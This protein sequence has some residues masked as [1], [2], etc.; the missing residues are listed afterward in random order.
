MADMADGYD[1]ICFQELWEHAL[2]GRIKEFRDKLRRKGF[3]VVDTAP[4][5]WLSSG[6]MVASRYPV[7]DARAHIF[8]A[9]RS[10]GWQAAVPKGVVHAGLRAPSGPLNVY[11]LHL[12]SDNSLLSS[13]EIDTAIKSAQLREAVQIVNGNGG[14]WIMAGDFNFAGD[15]P[16]RVVCGATGGVDVFAGPASHDTYDPR[17]PLAPI[18]LGVRRTPARLDRVFSNRAATQPE[19]L[20]STGLSDH[21]FLAAM[22]S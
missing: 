8:R 9:G 22:F 3:F 19:V 7:A 5:C 2:D 18:M 6:C 4:G 12:H 11:S 10:F 17:S 16:S 20:P 13:R 14:S 1:V 15:T 21:R